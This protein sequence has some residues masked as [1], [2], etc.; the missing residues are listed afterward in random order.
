MPINTERETWQLEKIK[1]GIIVDYQEM[2]MARF[3]INAVNIDKVHFLMLN[4]GKEE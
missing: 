2:V 1:H 4:I 3:H